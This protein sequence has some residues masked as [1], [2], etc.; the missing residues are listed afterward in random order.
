MG[1]KIQKV[2]D[3]L[4]DL[5]ILKA[6]KSASGYFI[7]RRLFYVLIYSVCVVYLEFL[8]QSNTNDI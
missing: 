7:L 1:T 5:L 3:E 6:W 4:N 2:M 8:L